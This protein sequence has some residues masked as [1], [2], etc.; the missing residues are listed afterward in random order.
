MLM[1]LFFTLLLQL[2]S[3]PNAFQ[4]TWASLQNLFRCSMRDILGF[5]NGILV[6][7]QAM[8]NVLSVTF[9]GSCCVLLWCLASKCYARL[10]RWLHFWFCVHLY[11]QN[12]RNPS[13][14]I[15]VNAFWQASDACLSESQ[16]H[17]SGFP[18]KYQK[19]PGDGSAFFRHG[20]A[21]LTSKN[22]LVRHM[23]F[24]F[25]SSAFWKLVVTS[26]GIHPTVIISSNLN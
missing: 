13:F 15:C 6:C 22:H 18:A 3:I 9:E 20:S 11:S 1:K 24:A 10:C 25:P 23:F 12:I 2:K 7:R 16:C 14:P 5:R 26:D 8:I 17:V 4:T 19:F 21:F